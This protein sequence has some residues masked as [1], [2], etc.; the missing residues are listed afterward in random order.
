MESIRSLRKVSLILFSIFLTAAFLTGCGYKPSSH[1]A[2]DKIKGKVY[3]DVDVDIEDPKNSVL[4]KDAMNEI[5]VSRFDRQLVTKKSEADTILIVKLNSVSMSELQKDEEGYV[6]LYRANVNINVKYNG[7][8]GN[9]SVTV[10]GSY[11]FSV[12]DGS[13]ISD[14]KRFEAIKIASN[15]ALEEIVS[16]FAVES[17]RKDDMPKD[18]EKDTKI[19]GNFK[20]SK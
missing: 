19:D 9:G 8:G 1:Y 12:D 13:T 18:E 4:V 17:F 7:P 20:I 5:V 2:K 16:K 6:N 10:S 14:S 11:D 3:V 15:K